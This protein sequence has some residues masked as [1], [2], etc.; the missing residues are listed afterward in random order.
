MILTL[1]LIA[2]PQTAQAKVRPG[3]TQER[4]FNGILGALLLVPDLR[5]EWGAKD[6]LVLTWP[7]TYTLEHRSFIPWK[8]ECGNKRT[9]CECSGHRATVLPQI[10][11]EPQHIYGV[12]NWRVLAGG[13]AFLFGHPGTTLR[14]LRK[15]R[16][17]H[18]SVEGFGVLGND[19]RGA[20]LGLGLGFR[21]IVSLAYRALWTHLG[22]RQSVTLDVHVF[23]APR[24]FKNKKRNRWLNH[25]KNLMN[26]LRASE[27]SRS[28]CH[29]QKL[30]ESRP[31][32]TYGLPPEPPQF[33]LIPPPNSKPCTKDAP[34]TCPQ[35]SP[36]K[37]PEK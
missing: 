34:T 31:P 17:V 3:S 16:K 21:G 22:P 37:A 15:R 1:S 13:R 14:D 26:E 32:R 18:L 6:G 10:F 30:M 29:Y 27:N 20:G 24:Y 35:N 8:I 36:Q 11:V 28:S 4:V 7:I 9:L 12:P 33:P 25:S 23:G 2:L 19:G 5:Y